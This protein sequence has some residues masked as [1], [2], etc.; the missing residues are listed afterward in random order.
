MRKVGEVA[1]VS[2]AQ[3]KAKIGQ[4]QD[5][6]DAQEYDDLLQR[7][8]ELVGGHTDMLFAGFIAVTAESK[9]ELEAAIAEI[10]RAATQSGCETRR[11]VGQQ[12]QAFTSGPL[13][14]RHS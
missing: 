11:L 2:D 4:L 6:S 3:Q 12:S 13:W 14:E 8:R 1:Y 7:E 10:Q 9:D 5:L